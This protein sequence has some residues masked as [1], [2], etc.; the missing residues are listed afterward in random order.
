MIYRDF[1][2]YWTE[3]DH[4]W[5]S[6]S[7]DLAEEEWKRFEPTITASRDDYKN[8]YNELCIKKAKQKCDIVDHLLKYI[9]IFSKEGSPKF[10]R[11]WLDQVNNNE[12]V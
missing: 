7:K 2:H 5:S 11:W 6:A 9:E 12:K 3:G 1:N 8:A 4:G 10:F